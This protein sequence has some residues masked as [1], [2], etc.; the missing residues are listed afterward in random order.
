M[1]CKKCGVFESDSDYCALHEPDPL[2]KMEDALKNMAG[3]LEAL[4]GNVQDLKM[5][6]LMRDEE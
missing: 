1:T 5:T 6:L 4:S 2:D 3:Y